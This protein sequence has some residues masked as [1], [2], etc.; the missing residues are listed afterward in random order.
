MMFI[1]IYCNFYKSSTFILF[2]DIKLWLLI[3]PSFMLIVQIQ[4][5]YTV[6]NFFTMN[7]SET[8]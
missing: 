4:L 1:C 5:L 3:F 6:S 7:V 2:T 8:S